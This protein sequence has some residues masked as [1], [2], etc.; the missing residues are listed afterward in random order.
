MKLKSLLTANAIVL[1]A[2][3]IFALFLPAKVLSM[4]GVEPG[5]SVELMA[6]YSGLGSLAIGLLTWFARNV[7]DLQTR[8]ALI[9]ALLITYVIGIIISLLGT[10]SGVMKIGWPVIGIYLLFALG[11]AYFQ[12]IKTR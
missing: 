10:I 12:F 11:Y 4:Y 6:Q 8:R 9:P 2:S 5:A 3:G 1:G 7:R